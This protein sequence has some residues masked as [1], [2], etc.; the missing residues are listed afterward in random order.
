MIAIIAT[1]DVNDTDLDP[2]EPDVSEEYEVGDADGSHV[3]DDVNTVGDIVGD[4]DMMVGDD[5]GTMDGDVVGH[6]FA[7]VIE[8]GAET[9][10][11][12][13]LLTNHTYQL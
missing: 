3:G 1:D 10:L 2:S 11:P 5:V 6:A 9:Q 7:A 13:P 8:I 4:D 12:V